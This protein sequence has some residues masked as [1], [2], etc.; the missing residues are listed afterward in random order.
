[1]APGAN[2]RLDFILLTPANEK[3]TVDFVLVGGDGLEL[4][5][6]EA[7]IEATMKDS[8]ND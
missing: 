6:A 2:R 8:K 1:M 7:Y 5:V 4:S 3:L